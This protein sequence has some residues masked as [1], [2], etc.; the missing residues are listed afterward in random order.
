MLGDKTTHGGEV[1][2]ASETFTYLGKPVA[3]VGDTVSCP[4][5]GGI[6]TIVEGFPSAFAYGN[7]I[8]VHDCLTSCGARLIAESAQNGMINFNDEHNPQIVSFGE[9]SNQPYGKQIIAIDDATGEPISFY[10]FFN[11][12]EDGNICMGRT[13]AEGKTPLINTKGKQE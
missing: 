11:E 3:R 2:T 13:D 7:P 4:K 1:I 8:A 10:P 5:C 6:H 9:L 12:S